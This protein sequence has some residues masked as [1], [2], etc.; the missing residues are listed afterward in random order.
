MY[1]F[2][3]ASKESTSIQTLRNTTLVKHPRRLYVSHSLLKRTDMAKQIKLRSARLECKTR[4]QTHA[5][6]STHLFTRAALPLLHFK[7][8]RV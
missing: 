5:P 4:D 8:L 3:Y 7:L 6:V 2:L 1:V